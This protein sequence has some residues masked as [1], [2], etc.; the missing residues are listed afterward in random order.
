MTASRDQA[1]V[2]I[3]ISLL[4][5]ALVAWIFLGHQPE[6]ETW[7]CYDTQGHP[8]EGVLI[9]CHY[10]LAGSNRSGV[11]FRFSDAEGKIIFDL[12]DDTP[13][14]LMRGYSCIYS[15]KLRS[16]A[17]GQ[18]E[19]WHEGQPIPNEAV[20]FDEWNNKIHLQSGVDDP[21]IWHNALGH[22]ICAYG[23]ARRNPHGGA[24]VDAE[25]AGLVFRERALFLEK[26][27]EQVVP[28]SYLKTGTFRNFYSYA[29]KADAGS[30]FK[31]IT[32]PLLDQT[33]TCY[34]SEGHVAKRAIMVYH[35]NL[36]GPGK[37]VI[38]FAESDESGR[39]I[40]DPD[41]GIPKGLNRTFVCSY[42]PKLRC[43]AT[44]LGAP[45]QY[46][47]PIPTESVYSDEESN[48]VFFKRGPE[49]PVIWHMALEGLIGAY[50]KSQENPDAKFADLVSRERSL[51]LEKYGEQVVP[52]EY[53]KT[54]SF[55]RSHHDLSNQTDLGLKFKDITHDLP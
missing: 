22:L 51:F 39:I 38:K 46:G 30:K 32:P 40:L 34:D 26:Y 7:H 33:W 5:V 27:G 29:R 19:R 55:Q 52:E 28:L 6:D 17:V 42:S 41:E 49:D 25:L 20:Y 15:P 11:N 18:G 9:V 8:A 3:S 31:D 1:W 21:L 43:G 45:W 24:K 10:G 48:R 14:G 23:G 16:G 50:S 54:G 2:K 36:P 13:D 44:G 47:Q 12:D 37:A 4:V 35:S 53:L